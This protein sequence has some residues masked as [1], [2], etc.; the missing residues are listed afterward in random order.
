MVLEEV[1]LKDITKQALFQVALEQVVKEIMLVHQLAG[2]LMVV[3]HQ[4]VAEERE[5]LVQILLELG[6]LLV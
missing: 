1:H 5:Q 3:P 4:A 2:R 6:L